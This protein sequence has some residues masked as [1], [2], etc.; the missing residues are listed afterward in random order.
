[1]Y[2][3]LNNLFVAR[4]TMMELNKNAYEILVKYNV[5]ACTDITG[6]GLIGH[7]KEMLTDSSLSVIIDSKRIPI[8]EGVHELVALGA[9]P[10]G[11]FLSF[12]H[13]TLNI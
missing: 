12:E 2:D 11:M 1:M 3:D 5:H 8:I 4:K 13:P 7:I 9:V 10:G 6:F